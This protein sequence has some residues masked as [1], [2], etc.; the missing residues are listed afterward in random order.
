M[1]PFAFRRRLQRWSRE[2]CL[3]CSQHLY[4]GQTCRIGVGDFDDAEVE[5]NDGS[6]DTVDATTP[7]LGCAG[8]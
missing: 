3:E 1:P 6:V 4:F 8:F 2:D 7:T 5:I